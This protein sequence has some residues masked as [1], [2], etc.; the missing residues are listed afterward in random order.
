M[1]IDINRILLNES[2][3][4]LKH[5]DVPVGALI[6]HNGKIIAKAHN[7]REK[8]HNVLGHAEIN[9]ILKASK[10]LKSWHLDQC[11]MYVTLKPCS[12]CDNIIKNSR[13]NS[14]HYYLDKPSFKKE[15]DKTKYMLIN[16][17]FSTLYLNM[18]SNFFKTKRK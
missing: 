16:D 5:G 9:C 17:R 6:V 11:D 3:K 14:I 1:D 12:I 13:I 2:K 15:Y 10:K 4:S 8:N 7:T 18:L